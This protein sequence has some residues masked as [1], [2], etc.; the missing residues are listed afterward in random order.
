[1]KFLKEA[2]GESS[3]LDDFVYLQ[4][5]RFSKY[6]IVTLVVDGK[7]SNKYF[8]FDDAAKD[9]YDSLIKE[10]NEDKEYYD[11]TQLTLSKVELNPNID[12]VQSFDTRLEFDEE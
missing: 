10:I 12:E 11:D 6:Y 8:A 2:Y 7:A 9:Y 4:N 5:N 3:E 1:M